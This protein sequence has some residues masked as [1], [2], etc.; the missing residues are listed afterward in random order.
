MSDTGS[1]VLLLF[2]VKVALADHSVYVVDIDGT[3]SYDGVYEEKMEP[4]LH[5]KRIGGATY[6]GDNYHFFYTDIFH[7]RYHFLYT[8]SRRP[9]TWI[10]GI[11]S[12]SEKVCGPAFSVKQ[13]CG[14]SA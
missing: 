11:H 9:Q 10:L 4:E 13:I 7:G 3:Y 6:L 8:D 12:K 2:L 14:K 5:Y 1:V